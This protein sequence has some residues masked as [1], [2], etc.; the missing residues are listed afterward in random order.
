MK[1]P[2][3]KACG[4][5]GYWCRGCGGMIKIDALMAAGYTE[6][7]ANQIRNYQFAGCEEAYIPC[8]LC[9][10][11]GDHEVDHEADSGLW[12]DFWKDFVLSSKK[13]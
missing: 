13:K 2:F 8:Y 3:C 7:E 10:R 1:G 12:A 5:C 4:D 6:E 9:N 11:S